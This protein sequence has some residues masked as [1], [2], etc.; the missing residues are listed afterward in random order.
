MMKTA[1]GELLELAGTTNVKKAIGTYSYAKGYSTNLEKMK[2]LS[3]TILEECALFLQLK[4]R[5]EF[6]SKTY[7]NRQVLADRII[8][9]IESHFEEQCDECSKIYRIRP[10]SAEPYLR[11]FLCMQGCHDCEEL[12]A[13]FERSSQEAG[14]ALTGS[15]WLC[16]G[17]RLKN[18]I[19]ASPKSQKANVTF[20][21]SQTKTELEEKKDNEDT[22]LEDKIEEEEGKSAKN[23][24]PSPRRDRLDELKANQSGAKA[25]VCPLYKKRQCPHG[26]SGQDEIEGKVCQ[27]THPRK[28]LKFCRFGKR[29]GGCTKGNSCKYY[30]PVLCKFSVK[31]NRCLNPECTYTHLKG[32][33]RSERNDLENIRHRNNST[34]SRPQRWRKD[35]TTSVGSR[36]SDAYRTP[37]FRQRTESGGEKKHNQHS[38]S[39]AFLEKLMENLRKGFEEQKTEMN[40]LKQGIDNKIGAIWKHVGSMNQPSLPP[41]PLQFQHQQPP[42]MM[43]APQAPW[44]GSLNPC[45]MY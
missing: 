16:R 4:V 39:N 26:P 27:Y 7:K 5:N 21:E 11:C 2:Q 34:D 40:L 1:I 43:P 44:N 22:E 25:D 10:G 24:K 38:S 20:D 17:C 8:M 14:G 29:K 37:F 13:R 33:M 9:K 32:T 18:D 35:S 19:Y 23:D 30:H 45:S 15:V 36:N 31:S 12:T 41:L 3:S 42:Q 28:C 6:N